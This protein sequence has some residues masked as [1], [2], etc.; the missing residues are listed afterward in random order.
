MVSI[1]DITATLFVSIVYLLILPFQ[2]VFFPTQYYSVK[3]VIYSGNPRKAT[4]ALA[5][6]F[7]FIL[8]ICG[9]L[10]FLKAN[11]MI[12]I[13]GISIGSFLCA[14][15]SI[16]QYQLF[17]F[18]KNKYKFLYFIACLLSVMLSWACA[19]FIMK[20]LLPMIFENKGFALIDNNGI[21][22]VA[23]VFGIISPFHIRKYIREEEQ[24]NPYLV[25][26]TYDADIYLTRRKM[27]FEKDFINQY[28]NE[29][30][31]AAREFEI[32]PVLLST[33]VQLEKINRGSWL[34]RVAERM[35]V[36]WI[37][38]YLIRRDATLGLAQ[39]SI[40]TA[41]RYFHKA[42]KLYITEMLKPEISIKLCAFMLNDIISDYRK[43]GPSESETLNALYED[44]D[45]SEDYKLC[46]YIAS[47]Y[48]CGNNN[49]LKKFVLVYADI[50]HGVHPSSCLGNIEDIENG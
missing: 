15:P 45:I 35:A 17:R 40:K 21:K 22:T 10:W 2:L 44:E 48:V 31:E 4:G 1:M 23:A 3:D 38:G 13:W 9:I 11:I 30:V 16:Y 25:H 20:I 8:M 41:K 7:M 12:G 19:T 26:D 50:I 28:Q 33:V 18:I 14:W 5:T 43:Y 27:S 42:P 49:T 37:P 24:D 32:M 36:R 29:I 47:Q 6:R 46:V 34:Y 39:I